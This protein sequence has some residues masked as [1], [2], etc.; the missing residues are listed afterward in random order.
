[1][2]PFYTKGAITSINAFST[3]TKERWVKFIRRG[4]GPDSGQIA[5]RVLFPEAALERDEIFVHT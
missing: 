4:F 3:A 5:L 2:V 1:M